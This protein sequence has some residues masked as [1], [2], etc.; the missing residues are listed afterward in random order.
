MQMTCFCVAQEQDSLN[1]KEK[2][3]FITNYTRHLNVKLEF[4]ND[5]QSFIIPISSNKIKV[6]PNLGHRYAAVLSYKFLTVRLGIRPPT[7][8]ESIRNNGESSSFRLK[9]IMLF[10]NWGHRLEYN[11]VKGYYTS[12]V[13]PNY[14]LDPSVYKNN[15]QFPE[16]TTNVFYG[17][18]LYKL[19]PNYSIRAT[20]SQTEAQ[21][22]STGSF[23]PS[24]D[25]AFYDIRGLDY[26]INKDGSKKTLDPSISSTSFDL[27]LNLGYHYTY[28]L[29]KWFANGQVKAGCG[30][31]FNWVSSDS[32]T[33]Y[34]NNFV[35]GYDLLASIGYNSD[36]IFF[37]TTFNHRATKE[38]NNV[39]TV[40]IF[41]SKNSYSI[42]LGYRFK[43]PKKFVKPI[44][45]IEERIPI[46]Q[47]E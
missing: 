7:S 20:I 22:K 15:I 14:K 46:L 23:I 31:S 8:E 26:F 28:V 47:R 12:D 17:S 38:P 41:S 44:D 6:Q 27:R 4:S 5:I 11:R 25:Y 21:K 29:K 37:G 18:T 33:N 32:E 30:N 16:M 45:D 42:Y 34:H 10:D 24:I 19:N 39:N 36:R 40:T 43:A 1:L 13:L 3:D 9:V 35:Y 2:D